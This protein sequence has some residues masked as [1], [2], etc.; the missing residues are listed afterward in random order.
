[1]LTTDFVILS[2]FSMF[3]ASMERSV[4]NHTPIPTSRLTNLNSSLITDKITFN[5]N[6]FPEQNVLFL[7]SS[8]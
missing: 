8:E 2:S 4:R 1:M 6:W 5:L 3:E 7:L